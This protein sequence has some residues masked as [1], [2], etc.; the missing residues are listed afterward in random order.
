MGACRR[1]L[2]VRN[3]YGEAWWLLA[4]FKTFK[5]SDEDIEKLRGLMV[6]P[7]AR[8][9]TGCVYI[10]RWARR[11]KIA[12]MRQAASSSIAPETRSAP[13]QVTNDPWRITGLVA[14]RAAV[15]ARDFLADRAGQRRSCAGPDLHPRHAA[16]RLHPGRADPRQ[17]LRWSK[18]RSELP[19]IP[20]WSGRLEPDPRHAPGRAL[21]RSCSPTSTPTR[22]PSSARSY[23]ERTRIQRKTDRPFSSTRCRTTGC[24]SASSA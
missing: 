19:D 2:E 10:S 5:F 20:C 18:A 4:D 7:G 23:L 6:R 21:S 12:G 9:K 11:W 14:N 16:R 13:L 3:D 1:A 22:C 17:P 8:L 24:M 15:H